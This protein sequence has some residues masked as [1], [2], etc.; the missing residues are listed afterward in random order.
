M[1]LQKNIIWSLSIFY[2]SWYL[3]KIT[4][5]IVNRLKDHWHAKFI[6]LALML[7]IHNKTKPLRKLEKRGCSKYDSV[8]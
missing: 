4:I 6:F 8:L 3:L 5:P 1:G 7:G 2:V